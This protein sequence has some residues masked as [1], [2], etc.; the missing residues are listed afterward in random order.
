[1]VVSILEA[2]EAAE[3]EK[4]V[5][6]VAMV[7]RAWWWFAISH[8]MAPPTQSQAETRQHREFTQLE[9][10]LLLELW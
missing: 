4:E 7:V 10:S 2:A 1:M 3:G 8:H 5:L 9:H 6:L